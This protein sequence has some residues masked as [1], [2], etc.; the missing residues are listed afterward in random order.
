M[1]NLA[2]QNAYATWVRNEEDNQWVVRDKDSEELYKF[3]AHWKEKDCMIA[4]K[5]GRKFETLAFGL[6]IGQG[7][8]ETQTKYKGVLKQTD[9]HIRFIEEQNERL[10]E[11]LEKLII[12]EEEKV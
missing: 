8:K 6:G 9:A 1:T 11:K 3:P 4:I 12:G 5:L 2:L 10:S 7:I